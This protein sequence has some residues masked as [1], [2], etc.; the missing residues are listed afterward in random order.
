[1]G[2]DP[3]TLVEDFDGLVGGP[4]VHFLAAQG[5]GHAVVMLFEDHM[6]VNVDPG[7][8]PDGVLIGSRRERRQPGL[9]Q[10]D[11]QLPAGI[12]PGASSPAG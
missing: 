12:D 8:F 2:C 10:F 3:P 11:K 1:M 4:D 7:H 5:V 9:V 6:I